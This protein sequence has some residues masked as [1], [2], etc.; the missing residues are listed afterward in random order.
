MSN[1]TTATPKKRKAP[2]ILGIILLIIAAIAGFF[3][4]NAH[5]NLKAM[6]AA[7]DAGMAELQ[8]RHT[9]TPVDAGDYSEIKMYGLMKFNV[10]QYDVQ[11]IGNLSVM[12]T[13]MGFM[14][15]VSFVV[16]PFEKDAPLLSMDYMY[17]LGNRKAYTEFYDLTPDVNTPDYQQTLSV[18]GELK[19]K[20][21]DITEQKTKPAWYDHLLTIALHKQLK[22]DDATMQTM[23]CDAVSLY[24]D[25]CGALPPMDDAQAAEKLAITQ[26]YCDHL[27]SKGGVS[28]NVFKSALGEEQTKD[29]FDKVFFGT[30]R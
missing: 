15:M 28:T 3:A 13:N 5:V 26:E 19:T 14:Q 12:T 16:T 29:F 18:I 30:A 9:V 24:L 2:V 17:I 6:H 10:S 20:Y 1:P 7:I 27:I 25:A 23:F 21:A 22:K 4:W 8:E 11:D